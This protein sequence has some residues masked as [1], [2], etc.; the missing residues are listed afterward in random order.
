MSYRQM[1][2]QRT[3]EYI[4]KPKRPKHRSYAD[5]QQLAIPKPGMRPRDIV[6][7]VCDSLDLCYRLKYH[8]RV[9]R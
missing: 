9:G 1:V 4:P 8:T 5:N 7:Y 6:G 3:Y 2:M